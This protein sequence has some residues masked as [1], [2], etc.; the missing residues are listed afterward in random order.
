MLDRGRGIRN[1][2]VAKHRTR[3]PSAASRS[4]GPGMAP[5]I[6]ALSS[7]GRLN[8]N[9]EP[10][11]ESLSRSGKNPPPKKSVNL[12]HCAPRRGPVS[13]ILS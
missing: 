13:P 7:I 3:N 1:R 12:R 6:P 4:A 2:I 5:S 8:V 10:A 9:L 11:L